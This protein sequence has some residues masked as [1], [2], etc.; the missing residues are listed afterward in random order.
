MLAA[1]RLRGKVKV[2]K[3]LEYTMELLRLYKVNHL[4]LVDERLKPMLKKVNAFITFGEVRK[5]TLSTLLQKRARLEGDK[6][7]SEAFLKEKKLKSF[8]D[9]SEKIL[10]K[11][12]SLKELGIKPVFRLNAARKGLGR[13]GTKQPF[14]LGG[15]L[16]YRAEKINELIERMM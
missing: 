14:H 8:E 7:V 3:D 5:E 15:A 1:I 11:K 4:V 16:G 9:L 13:L 12:A 6:K 2:K 10:A